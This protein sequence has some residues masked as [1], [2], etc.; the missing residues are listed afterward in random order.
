MTQSLQVGLRLR[1]P[2]CRCD[3][4][5]ALDRQVAAFDSPLN[6]PAEHARCPIRW[7]W[8]TTEELL[9]PLGYRILNMTLCHH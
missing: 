5:D 4:D 6:G 1:I 8:G 3:L 7:F 2:R 9:V